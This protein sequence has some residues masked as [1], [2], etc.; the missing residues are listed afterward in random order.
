MKKYKKVLKIS[1]FVIFLFI[2]ILV[3]FPFVF[4][5]KIVEL[6]KQNL[7]NSL[8]ATVD[9]KEA[10][11]SI[12]RGFPS[13]TVVLNG[14]TVITSKP[15]ANDT[16]FSADEIVLKIG[17]GELF[18]DASETVS[19]KN[20][21][22]DKAHLNILINKEAQANYDITKEKNSANL[23][24]NAPKANFEFSVDS[25]EITNSNMH[26]LDESTGIALEVNEINHSG[27]GD[28][29]LENSKLSTKTDALISFS[30]DSVN[31]LNKNP[32]KLEA[33]LG[34]DL[35]ESTYS[36]LKN[37]G[38]INQLPLVFDGF[39]KINEDNQEV[40]ISF[41][42]PSSDF[43]NF[44]AVLPEV[45]VKNIEN[46]RTSGNFEIK[47][48]IEG[49]V[50]ETHIPK[51]NISL[52]S[53]DA[54]FQYPNLPKAV[55]N[56][57]IKTFVV[58]K[59]GLVKDTYIEIQQLSF[60][61]DEDVF[62]ANAKFSN[63]IENP[64]INAHI[65]GRLN[66]KNLSNAYP[67][68]TN[69]PLSGVLDANV[70]TAFDMRTVENGSY[71]KTHNT[72]TLVL[73]GFN[74]ESEELAKPFKIDKAAL[75][76]NPKK[77][78]LNSLNAKTGQ[79]D[80]Q[81][82]GSMTNLLGYLFNNEDVKGQFNMSSNVFAVND[83]M[84]KEVEEKTNSREKQQTKQNEIPTKI[85]IPSFLD[86]TINAKAG[87]V[88]YDNITLKDVDG[89]LLIADEKATLVNLK[90]SL[91]D[92]RLALNGSVSTKTETPLFDMNLNIDAF[93]I[94]SSF[95]ELE[96]FKALAPIANAMQ[97][98]LNAALSL[99]GNLNDDFTPNLASVSGNTLAEFLSTKINP[100]NS[101]VLSLVTNQLNFID[102]SNLNL[103]SLK[104]SLVFEN[105]KVK[106]KPFK[107]NYQDIGITVEGGHGFD[108]SMDY[109]ITFDVP[110]KYLGKEAASLIAS[111][112]NEDTETLKVPVAASIKGSF[113]DPKVN[114]DLKQAVTNLTKELA[115]KQKNQ[116][117]NK[118]KD[119]VKDALGDFLG[120]EKDTIPNDSVTKKDPVKDT[121]GTLIKGLFGKKNKKKDSV[122]N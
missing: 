104:T 83:F 9:F 122:T 25:Y 34:I 105:G 4:K 67:L 107:F 98:K 36:L 92:G 62:N 119:A 53:D 19:I 20:F 49:V 47:G 35:K 58:N 15:F 87:T 2:G 79:T 112:K 50:D 76:F 97:G 86:C 96:L 40:K 73:S 52:Q 115:A 26:Y 68:T 37:E 31:Y 5:G 1:A 8:N 111:L 82:N 71:E 110:A 57:S 13:A 21:K 6:I 65:D 72:G 54:M 114:T 44:L 118:G 12:F 45:Y 60:R 55:E 120:S 102:F 10:D 75:T 74:Y 121:A 93:N 101:K 59:T 84:V 70:T 18:K 80:I 14:T 22:V 88:F 117:V 42:T 24:E 100:E 103:D 29:S 23:S 16:L 64:Y 108:A 89:T 81:A 48:L 39:V 28:L 78:T 33:L 63:L 99:S 94:A 90:S 38:V 43:K 69:T 95:K 116:L 66:L 32:V 61:I 85:K 51:L 30:M 56:I 106:V 113:S 3:A 7:N 46:V 41:E 27:K 11:L 77:V 17:I 91:F 109:G